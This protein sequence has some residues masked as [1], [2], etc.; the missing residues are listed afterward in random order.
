MNILR[1]AALQRYEAPQENKMD[2][3]GSHGL[4]VHDEPSQNSDDSVSV[5]STVY[6]DDQVQFDVDKILADGVRGD[7]GPVWLGS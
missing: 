7:G 1:S 5:T 3:N 6:D 4:F 2:E